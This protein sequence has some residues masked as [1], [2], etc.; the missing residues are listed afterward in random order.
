MLGTILIGTN[1]VAIFALLPAWPYSARWGY[2]PTLVTGSLF[3]ILIVLAIA[4]II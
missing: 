3:V 2:C 4:G 1:I